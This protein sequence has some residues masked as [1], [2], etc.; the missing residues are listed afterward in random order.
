MTLP[1]SSLASRL[2]RRQQVQQRVV[3]VE[4]DHAVPVDPSA[5]MLNQTAVFLCSHMSLGRYPIPA[6]SCIRGNFGRNCPR[7][8]LDAGDI[9]LTCAVGATVSTAVSTS[10]FVDCALMVSMSQDII[11]QSGLGLCARVS[12]H[13]TTRHRVSTVQ[14]PRQ[15]PRGHGG[16]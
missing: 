10:F 8:L 1:G 11:T 2:T 7:L 16:M 15:L 14:P 9:L 13:D 6:P 5:G 4:A 12:R 3:Y